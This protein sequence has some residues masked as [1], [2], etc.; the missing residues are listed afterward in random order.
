MTVDAWNIVLS[1]T[2]LVLVTGGGIWLKYVVGQQLKSKDSAIGALEAAIKTKDAQIDALKADSSPAIARA[3]ADMRKHADQM[4]GDSQRLSEQLSAL[5]QKQKE[6]DK[7]VIV[8]QASSEAK[9]L[10]RATDILDEFLK[11]QLM[12]PEAVADDPIFQ[13]FLHA[14]NRMLDETEDR[15]NVAKSGIRFITET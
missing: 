13:S 9:G 3:Y 1:S 2:T 6:A 10:L 14:Y 11:P 4:T 12:K 5:T 8:K 7:F 15:V